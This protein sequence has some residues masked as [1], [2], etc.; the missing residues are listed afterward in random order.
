MKIKINSADI[1]PVTDADVERVK[2]LITTALILGGDGATAAS[3][4][5]AAIAQ[6][7]ALSDKQEAVVELAIRVLAA[8]AEPEWQ[9]RVL[10]A[11]DAIDREKGRVS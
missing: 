3:L 2:H 5:V 9:K 7:A 1:R 11:C 4:L 6:L 8:E 10:A